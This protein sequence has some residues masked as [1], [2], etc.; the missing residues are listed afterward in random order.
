MLR[1]S[2]RPN[3]FSLAVVGFFFQFADF[4]GVREFGFEMRIEIKLQWICVIDVFDFE[5]EFSCDGFD[6][7]GEFDF[8]ICDFLLFECQILM[9]RSLDNLNV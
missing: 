7:F 4:C 6:L 9:L 2:K 5:F 3:R 1:D 8:A